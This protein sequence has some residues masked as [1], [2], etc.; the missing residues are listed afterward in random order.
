MSEKILNF[1]IRIL[2]VFKNKRVQAYVMALVGITAGYAV[3]I[4]IQ[5]IRGTVLYEPPI[6]SFIIQ[7]LLFWFYMWKDERDAKKNSAEEFAG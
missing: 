6:G 3:N 4:T 5:C 2:N 7:F 1:V